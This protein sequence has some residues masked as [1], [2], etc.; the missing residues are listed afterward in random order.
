MGET[1][2]IQRFRNLSAPTRIASL[3]GVAAVAVWSAIWITPDVDESEPTAQQ[4]SAEQQPS[5]APEQP[6][7]PAALQQ[8][9]VQQPTTAPRTA[10]AQPEKPAPAQ[11]RDPRAELRAAL[12]SDNAGTRIDALRTAAELRTVQALPDLLALDITRD[13][14]VAPTVFQVTGRL[15]QHADAA[16]RGAAV[17]QLSRWLQSESARDGADA[18][19]NVSVLV[20]T[21]ADFQAPEAESALVEV[22]QSGKQPLHV[23]TLA[24][25]GLAK[26]GT[27][28]AQAALTQFRTQLGQ[29]ERQGFELELQREA[30]Q[31]TDRALAR[32]SR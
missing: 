20:E 10:P 30:E 16:Q 1:M 25:E 23:Q 21:L 19:G 8:P 27:P 22:L 15:A 24:V 18:R 4:T 2:W 7:A 5:S 13:P 28:A 9:V 29:T 11:E 12:A 17:S 32:L 26:L 14:E 6:Q 31:A 3:A